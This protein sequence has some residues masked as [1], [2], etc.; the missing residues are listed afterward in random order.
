MR[1]IPSFYFL[2][3]W[4]VF[5]PASFL[6]SE[7]SLSVETLVEARF[8]GNF[9]ISDETLL[10]MAGIEVGF[11]TDALILEDIRQKL[12]DCGRFEWVE[13]TKRYRS[14]ARNDEVVLV[15][16][17]K[18]KESA[19]NKFMYSPIFAGSD[20]YGLTYGLRSTAKDLLGRQ[21]RISIPLTWGGVRRVEVEGEFELTNPVIRTLT[22]TVGVSRKKHPYYEIGDFRKE[23]NVTVKRKLNQF[24]VNA[25]TGWTDVD[26]GSRGGAFVTLG[27]GLILDTRQDVNLPRNAVYAEIAWKRLTLFDAERGINVYTADFR[28]YKGLFGQ[29][30]LAGQFYYSGADGTLPD[31]ERPFLGGANTLRGYE[32]GAF[33]GDNIAT[34][35]L[36]LRLPLSS[37]RHIYRSGVALFFDS[38][39]AYDHGVALGNAKFNHGAG[40]GAFLL[41]MGFGIKADLGYN[42]H[43][44]SFRV[45]FS[46]GFRF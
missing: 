40:V 16:V 25:Q 42:M 13:V 21:E 3:A 37:L 29:T 32:P 19:K 10:Q 34:A 27:T 7:E 26:F 23:V 20:E 8:R 1:N 11:T 36:E 35:S 14:I 46:S 31:Y 6:L 45:H 30:I 17:V 44:D 18:E 12:L 5:F 15:I 33:I 2:L 28:G 24:E 41:I 22:A 39:A 9:T 4:L 38:G 43:D